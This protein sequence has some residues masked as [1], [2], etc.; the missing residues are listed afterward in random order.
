MRRIALYPI[1]VP[2]ILLLVQ[3][4]PGDGE[5]HLVVFSPIPALWENAWHPDWPQVPAGRS[6]ARMVAAHATRTRNCPMLLS[7]ELGDPYD[8]TSVEDGVQFDIDADG[9]LD[10]V[11]WTGAGSDVAFLALDQDGSGTITSGRELI[12]R[13]TT[14]R[15]T[16]GPNALITLATDAL[17]GVTKPLMDRENPLFAK[18]LLWTDA[19]H[20]GISDARELRPAQDLLSHIGLGFSRHHR[21]DRHGNE[22]RFRGMVYLRGASDSY[23]FL[24]RD[25]G[26]ARLR[27]MYDACLVTR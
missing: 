21:R 7:V 2:A 17:D 22:S 9:D 3:I 5:L 23:P 26:A 19:N 15:A 27:S 18:L 20:N 11:S 12:G 4:R 16:N 6:E 25:E 8:L 1:V 14:A 24:D 10:Q 13:H